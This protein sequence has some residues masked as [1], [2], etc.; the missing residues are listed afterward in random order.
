MQTGPN[1]LAN[2]IRFLTRHIIIE[3][4]NNNTVKESEFIKNHI[5]IIKDARKNKVIIQLF[6]FLFILEKNFQLF[7]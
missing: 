4:S 5:E 7:K 2:N 6:H 1:P 3:L